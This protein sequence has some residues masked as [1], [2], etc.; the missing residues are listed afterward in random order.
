MF[1]SDI[2]PWYIIKEMQTKLLIIAWV[3]DKIK[4]KPFKHLNY[5]HRTY[6]FQMENKTF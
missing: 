2:L 4:L 3:F 6:D 1:A 5:L